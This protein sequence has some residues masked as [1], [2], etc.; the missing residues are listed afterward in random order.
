MINF[1]ISSYNKLRFVFST[2]KP[3]LK[4][5]PNKGYSMY[6]ATFNLYVYTGHSTF[7]IFTVYRTGSMV[8]TAPWEY[9][10][11]S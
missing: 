1:K 10:F 4:D 11:T 3:C 7:N 6:V 8:P 5:T 2:V 9:S